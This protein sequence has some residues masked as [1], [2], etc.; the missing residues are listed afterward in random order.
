MFADIRKKLRFSIELF[1]FFLYLRCMRKQVL[2]LT[3]LCGKKVKEIRSEDGREFVNANR[4]KKNK[5]YDSQFQH[6]IFLI[7]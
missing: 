4:I 5:L 6:S 1:S 2:Y 7:N 3:L